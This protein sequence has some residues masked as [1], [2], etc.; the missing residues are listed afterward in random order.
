MLKR[1]KFTSIQ[2]RL[3]LFFLAFFL[4]VSVS[5]GAT[6][7]G[8]QAQRDDALVINLGGRQRMLTQQMTRLAVEMGSQ[9]GQDQAAA[10]ES[11]EQAFE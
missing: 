4:L 5:V 2:N 1:I 9:D 3:G 11:A 8:I 7:W 6:F 10:L